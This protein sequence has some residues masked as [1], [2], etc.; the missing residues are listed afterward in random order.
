MQQTELQAAK[1]YWK[2]HHHQATTIL[3]LGQGQDHRY[4]LVDYILDTF[5]PA[6]VLEFGCSSGR[7]L[8]IMA[9]KMRERGK[10]FFMLWGLEQSPVTVA[11]GRQAFKDVNW[12]KGDENDLYNMQSDGFDVVFT[13]SV[14]DHIPDPTWKLVYDNL[15]RVAKKAVVL[16]EPVVVESQFTYTGDL[17]KIMRV[18]PYTYS[19]DYQTHDPKLELVKPL[20]IPDAAQDSGQHYKLFVRRK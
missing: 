20:P 9:N 10:K 5:N 15:V 3:P 12:I 19:W 1:E 7:N 8:G 16:L 18:V 11:S 14:L 2:T 13:C 6:S 4:E 17:S